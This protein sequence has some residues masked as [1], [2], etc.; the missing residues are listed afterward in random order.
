EDDGHHHSLRPRAGRAV[1]GHLDDARAREDGGVEARRLLAIRVEP[2][3]RGDRP[4]GVVLSLGWGCHIGRHARRG[5]I[6]GA[7]GA[8]AVRR[9]DGAAQHGPLAIRLAG[10]AGGRRA[11]EEEALRA[12]AAELA[13]DPVLLAR[14]DPLDDEV[15]PE[16]VAEVDDALEQE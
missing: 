13:Y 11:P 9:S 10:G 6:G 4:H 1:G 7:G 15:E 5:L 14:L 8:E 12:L 16:R 2:E 3:A